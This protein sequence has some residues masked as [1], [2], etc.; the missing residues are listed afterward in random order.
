MQNRGAGE[1]AVSGLSVI[2]QALLQTQMS[3]LT[4][5]HL[6]SGRCADAASDEI[7]EVCARSGQGVQ[8]HVDDSPVTLLS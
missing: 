5:H 8:L 7:V 3:L 4:S 6:P 1:R 2:L